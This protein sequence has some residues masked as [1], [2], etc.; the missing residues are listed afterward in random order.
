[1]ALDELNG[2]PLVHESCELADEARFI[3]PEVPPASV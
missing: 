1:M 2:P 3:V